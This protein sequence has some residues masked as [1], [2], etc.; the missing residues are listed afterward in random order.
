MEIGIIGLPQS[1]KTSL[2]N[3][4]S[5]LNVELGFAG[6]RKSANRAVAKVPDQRLD[7]LTALYNPKRKVHATA[8]YID[9]VGLTGSAKS[10]FPAEFLQAVKPCEALL[11]CVRAFEDADMPHPDGDPDPLGDIQRANDEFLFSDLAICE[12]RIERLAK[13]VMKIKDKDRVFELDTLRKCHAHLEQELPLRALELDE[14]E[15]KALRSYAFLT[16]KPMLI[17]LNVGEDAIGS[18]QPLAQV[19]EALADSGIR[20][21]Q[22][23]AR[24][25]MEL[26]QMEDED[27][28]E[29]LEEYGI[30]EAAA[31]MVIRESFELLELLTFFTVGDDECRAW[32]VRQ[33]STAPVAAG[34]IHSDIQKGFIRGEVVH[35][36]DLLEAGSMSACKDKGTFRLEGKDY[37]V[38]EGDVI[39]FRFNV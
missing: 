35:S 25:E 20:T 3:A 27:R 37:L 39:H 16:L 22:L 1:G 6:G 13:E 31:G 14:H 36:S 21:C 17:V 9:L 19:Q 38:K 12:G 10:G 5:G 33:G 4:L 2:F 11:L 32:T 24:I 34:A 8:N 26:S 30:T 23:C 7:A 29:F 28:A 18:D 15:L